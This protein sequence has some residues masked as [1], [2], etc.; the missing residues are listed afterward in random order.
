MIQWI[1]NSHKE[2]IVP[3]VSHERIEVELDGEH[4]EDF[5]EKILQAWTVDVIG[6]DIVL[7]ADM[8]NRE[9]LKDIVWAVRLKIENR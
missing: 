8:G 4:I 7:D 5:K 1:F 3:H 2:I 9:V 6:N